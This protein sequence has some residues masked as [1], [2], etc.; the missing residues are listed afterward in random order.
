ME[1]T[2]SDIIRMFKRWKLLFFTIVILTTVLTVFIYKLLPKTYEAETIIKIEG[3]GSSLGGSFSGLLSLVGIQKSSSLDDYIEMIKS[4]KVVGS[5]VDK[6]DLVKK[7]L[8]PEILSELRNKGYTDN[9][10]KEVVIRK[11]LDDLEVST[12]GKSSLISIK[13]PS[14]DPK[15]S[16]EVVKGILDE[17]QNVVVSLASKSITTK[18][19][20]LE[21]K[22]NEYQDELKNELSKMVEF[23]KKYGLLSM[24]DELAANAEMMAKLRMLYI[25]STLLSSTGEGV[26]TSPAEENPLVAQLIA[27][28]VALETDLAVATLTYS[29]DSVQINIIEKRLETLKQK[30]DE[31][32][33]TS[34]QTSLKLL[35]YFQ[36]DSSRLLDVAVDYY[37]MQSKIDLLKNLG[38]F[39]WQQ[40]IQVL[41][42]EVSLL[43]PITVISEPKL[44]HI[45][46]TLSIKLVGAIGLVLG[47]FLGI[48]GVFWKESSSPYL[49]DH[50][51]FSNEHGIDTFQVTRIGNLDKDLKKI[52]GS[53]K[54]LEGIVS[55][56]SPNEGDGKTSIASGIAN[57][58]SK[59]GKKVL[60]IDGN[61]LN[62][63]LSRKLGYDS[64]PGLS[65]GKLDV[66]RI[67]DNVDF[68][69]AGNKEEMTLDNVKKLMNLKNDYDV[70]LIDSPAYDKDP[71]IA[72]LYADVADKV[73]LV[74]SEMN[75]LKLSINDL[76]KIIESDSFEVIY[77]KV[78]WVK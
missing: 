51:I 11:V 71:I 16:Y 58:L 36:N 5:V 17:F 43:S 12:V 70:I 2:L 32:R 77:N 24:E 59:L 52:V 60:L 38:T 39:A 50:I 28:L 23:Q 67:K 57:E 46:K 19:E 29:P 26:Y 31:L 72:S 53:L 33:N 48:L 27:K 25:N 75:S 65:D 68:L 41:L 78:R 30:I 62:K 74:L 45:P 76:M 10:I 37:F 3:T 73:L 61:V 66:I 42:S 44:I 55:I 8:K 18:K 21:K 20:F 7:L 22:L 49:T 4:R 34:A 64:N 40:Y 15:I 47:I 56:I 14:K 6:K 35:K 1:L 69:P 63:D 9:D 13:Y 54:T